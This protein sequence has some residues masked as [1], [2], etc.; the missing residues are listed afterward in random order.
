LCAHRILP[1]DEV[2][3]L[4]AYFDI[5]T[6]RAVLRRVRSLLRPDGWLFLG[7][8]ETTI[9]I[10]GDFERVTARRTSVYRPGAGQRALAGA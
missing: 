2:A 10:D 3:G 9:G 6:K 4:V 7:S 5:E 8:A 1:L